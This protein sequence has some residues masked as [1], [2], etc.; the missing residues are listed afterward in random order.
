MLTDHN[1]AKLYAILQK[2]LHAKKAKFWCGQNFARAQALFGRGFALP[3]RRGL[4]ECYSGKSGQ[5]FL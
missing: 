1:I 5:A 2:F 3:H 4:L